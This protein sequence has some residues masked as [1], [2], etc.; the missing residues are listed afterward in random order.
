MQ[1]YLGSQSS[2]PT[3]QSFSHSLIGSDQQ[4]PVQEGQI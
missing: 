3:A 1:H 2:A 4:N